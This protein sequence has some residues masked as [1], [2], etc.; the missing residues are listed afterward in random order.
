ML[1]YSRIEFYSPSFSEG[2][3][4]VGVPRNV[5][6]YLLAAA[7]LCAGCRRRFYVRTYSEFA[8]LSDESL[9]LPALQ[10]PL[11]ALRFFSLADS[12]ATQSESDSPPVA[13]SPLRRLDNAYAVADGSLLAVKSFVSAG[14]LAQS[15]TS[16]ALQT[17]LPLWR[18]LCRPDCAAALAV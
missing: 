6:R 9:E 10:A 7:V 18:L 1:F 2:A 13:E 5:L 11:D 3:A 8:L 4:A 15:V 14:R 17:Q 16:N 12:A